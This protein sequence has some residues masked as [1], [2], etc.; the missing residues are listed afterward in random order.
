MALLK[1]PLF[2]VGPAGDQERDRGADGERA[3]VAAHREAAAAAGE[4]LRHHALIGMVDA[5]LG[6]PFAANDEAEITPPK[7]TVIE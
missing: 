6:R 4:A 5:C 2:T 1:R 3:D 7:N